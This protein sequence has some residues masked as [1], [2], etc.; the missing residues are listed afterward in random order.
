[1]FGRA[2]FT[3][4]IGTGHTKHTMRSLKQI[5]RIHW[6]SMLTSGNPIFERWERPPEVLCTGMTPVQAA[7]KHDAARLWKKWFPRDEIDRVE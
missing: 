1:M 4:P 5:Y 3:S 7:S 2:D 6:S